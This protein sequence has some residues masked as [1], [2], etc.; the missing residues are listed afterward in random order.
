MIQLRD[1]Y[2]SIVSHIKNSK[3]KCEFRMNLAERV[4]MDVEAEKEGD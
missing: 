1:Q 4:K 3:S 2:I